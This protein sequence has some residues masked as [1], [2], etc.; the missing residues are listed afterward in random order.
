MVLLKKLKNTVN[1]KFF[2]YEELPFYDLQI[3]SEEFNYFQKK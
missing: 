1:L 2:G 3:E